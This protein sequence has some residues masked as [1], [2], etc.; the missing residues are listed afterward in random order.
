[1]TSSKRLILLALLALAITL[2]VAGC[3][4]SSDSSGSSSDTAASSDGAPLSKAAFIKQVD[5]ACTE[6][7]KKVEAEFSAYLKKEKI[8]EIGASGESKAQ[9]E[10]RKADVITTIGVPAYQQQVDEIAALPVPS[11]DAATIEE[12][13]GAAEEGIEKVE[14]EPVAAYDGES[15]AFAKADKIAQKYGFKVCGSS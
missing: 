8:Q 11:E 1:M 15:K 3:G 9:A 10:A 7:Q 6:E 4:S 5:A 2:I 14:E 12:F 13:V